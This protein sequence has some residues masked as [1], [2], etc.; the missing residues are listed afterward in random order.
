MRQVSNSFWPENA[1]RTTGANAL[2]TGVNEYSTFGFA[3][4]YTSQRTIN[5]Q[6]QPIQN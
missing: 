4:A 5:V 3:T 1:A 2:P 6:S